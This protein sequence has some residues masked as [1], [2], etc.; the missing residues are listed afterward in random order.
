MARKMVVYC[1]LCGSNDDVEPVTVSREGVK[2][3]EID[4]CDKCYSKHLAVLVRKSRATARVAGR[5]QARFEVVDLPPQPG[6]GHTFISRR[7]TTPPTLTLP[8]AGGVLPSKV[9][10]SI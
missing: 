1:D 10:F 6:E 4:L 8:L 9:T 7:V 5:K 2:S 3:W